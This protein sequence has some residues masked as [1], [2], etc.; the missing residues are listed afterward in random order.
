LHFYARDAADI[1]FFYCKL[2]IQ[3]PYCKELCLKLLDVAMDENPELKKKYQP[4][5]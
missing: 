5:S 3:E 2:G 4:F 1:M